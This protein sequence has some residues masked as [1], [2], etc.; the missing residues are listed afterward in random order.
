M[1]PPALLHTALVEDD[2]A[3]RHATS[4]ALTLEGVEVVAF[5]NAQAALNALSRDYPGAVISDVRMPGMDGLEFF[6]R[7]RAIDPELPVILTTGHGDIAM[8]VDAMKNGAADFL[9]KPYSSTDLIRAVRRAADRRA[10]A[11]ENRRLQDELGRRRQSAILGSSDAARKLRSVID[12]VAKS[13]IDIVL[14]GDPGTG[15]S[16]AA[17]LVHDLGPRRNRPFVTIDADILAREDAELL[18]FGREPGAGLSRS[19]LVERASSGTLFLDGIEIASGA[20][21]TRLLALL[22]K[23]TVLP[24]GGDRPRQLNLRIIVARHNREPGDVPDPVLDT[25]EHRIGA[26]R[27][28][29]PPL[30]ARREDIA[31]LFRH[32]VAHHALDLEQEPREIGE[33]QWRYIQAHQW[34]GNLHEL[35]GYARQFV[36]GLADV[37]SLLAPSADQR[38]LQQIV[39]DF[40]RTVLEDALQQCRGDIVRLQEMLQTPRKTIYDKLAKYDLKPAR[41][42]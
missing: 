1:T 15:K 5:P 13:E 40:E 3:L 39:A 16:F 25:L 27:I 21:R 23:R 32:F 19:G 41:Y 36:L 14:A 38:S 37:R 33:A 2:D 42:R 4:Q 8:A 12:A 18:L 10:L 31:E 9:A 35:S 6:D 30:A 28:D 11:L 34:P 22:E 26:V 24:L 29:L 7:L 20:V 17:R